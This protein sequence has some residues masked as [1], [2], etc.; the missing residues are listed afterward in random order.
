MNIHY[1][2][3][4]ILSALCCLLILIQVM[5]WLSRRRRDEAARAYLVQHP[6][7]GRIYEVGSPEDNAQIVQAVRQVNER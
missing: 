7:P 4:G 3:T 1:M 5:T 2:V 6:L